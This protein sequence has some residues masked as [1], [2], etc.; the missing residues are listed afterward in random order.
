MLTD[1]IGAGSKVAAENDNVPDLRGLPHLLGEKRRLA[2]DKG[3]EWT[4]KE[5]VRT[6]EER[7]RATGGLPRQRSGEGYPGR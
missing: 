1:Y 6:L 3:S 7:R 5:V 4:D 2:N